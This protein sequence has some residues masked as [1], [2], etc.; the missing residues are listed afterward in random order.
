VNRALTPLLVAN[1]LAGC[2]AHSQLA[3]RAADY[4]SMLAG[5]DTK[6]K[7]SS[8]YSPAYR[9]L[10]KREALAVVD[11]A[12]TANTVEKSRYPRA[13]AGDIA[14]HIEG[15]FAL[16]TANP[17]LGDVY[18]SQRSTKWVKAG[19]RWYLYLGSAVESKAYGPFPVGMKPPKYEPKKKGQ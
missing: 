11:K 10:M 18:K 5:H 4:Y 15:R 2:S 9:K 8:Y 13:K 12:I 3:G 1:V 7:L 14:T 17:A 19:T 6:A 16:T